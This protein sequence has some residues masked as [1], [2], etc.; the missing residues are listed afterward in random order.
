MESLSEA[1]EHDKGFRGEGTCRDCAVWTLIAP[2]RTLAAETSARELPTCTS[3]TTHTWDTPALP[4][5]KLASVTWGQNR[6]LVFQLLLNS[7][8]TLTLQGRW[9][10]HISPLKSRSLILP[11][12]NRKCFQSDLIFHEFDNP[13]VCV[14]SMRE[15]EL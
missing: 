7:G 2:R 9:I 4:T 11:T 12:S 10:T 13:S 1:P 3:I 14:G 8:T 15:V 5:V 6:I